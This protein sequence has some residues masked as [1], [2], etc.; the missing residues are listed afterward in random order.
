[1]TARAKLAQVI[2]DSLFSFSELGFQEMETQRYL[3]ELLE[4]NGFTVERGVAGIPLGVGGALEQ[5]HGRPDDCARPR[6]STAFPKRLRRS[7]AFPWHEPLVE[8]APGAR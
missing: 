1:M 8:G 4:K 3:G 7:P 6:T 5:W 2:N